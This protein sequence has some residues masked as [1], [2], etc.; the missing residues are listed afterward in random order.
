[1][2]LSFLFWWFNAFIQ[3]Y[4]RN[5]HAHFLPNCRMTSANPTVAKHSFFC[6]KTPRC[7]EG[8]PFQYV[9]TG[10]L[11]KNTVAVIFDPPTEECC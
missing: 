8:D 6:Q 11:L 7:T 2:Q 3:K 5:C 4:S 10:S 1:M 9:I